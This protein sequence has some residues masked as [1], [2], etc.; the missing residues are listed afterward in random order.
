MFCCGSESNQDPK[1]KALGKRIDAIG[2]ALFFI[3]IG[4]LLLTPEGTVPET[5][6]LVGAGLIMLGGN[7]VRRLNGIKMEGFTVVLGVVALVSGLV[8]FVGADIPV[9]PILLIIL[10][11]SII[12]GPLFRKCKK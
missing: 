6:W 7:I 3:M 5:A 1:K 2:W 12:L 9:F 11:V 4:G 10:G 8:G